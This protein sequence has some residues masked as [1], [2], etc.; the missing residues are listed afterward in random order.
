MR[1]AFAALVLTLVQSAG[2]DATRRGRAFEDQLL[3]TAS[4]IIYPGGEREHAPPLPIAW[5]VENCEVLGFATDRLALK[6]PSR[7]GGTC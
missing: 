1:L 7:T 2:A 4:P 6:P 3:K 5:Y